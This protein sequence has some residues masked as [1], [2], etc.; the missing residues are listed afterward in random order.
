MNLGNMGEQTVLKSEKAFRQIQFLGAEPV[1]YNIF[2]ARRKARD[3]KA[4]QEYL[5][6]SKAETRAVS[7]I[8]KV[9]GCTVEDL[10]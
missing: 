8:A 9:L 6:I 4:R 3:A 5:D 1:D 10:I 7:N 2:F